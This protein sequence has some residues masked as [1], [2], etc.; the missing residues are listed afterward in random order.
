M[1]TNPWNTAPSTSFLTVSVTTIVPEYIS[2][3]NYDPTIASVFAQA[4]YDAAAKMP[5]NSRLGTKLKARGAR[6]LKIA[7]VMDPRGRR[8]PWWSLPPNLDQAGG[9]AV[10]GRPPAPGSAGGAAGKPETPPGGDGEA[11]TATARKARRRRR[12]GMGEEGL[13]A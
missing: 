2:P 8:I 12:G 4:E 11:G 13:M 9:A 1:L 10:A 5:P 7:H 3:G 6:L